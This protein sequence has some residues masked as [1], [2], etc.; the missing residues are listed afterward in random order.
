MARRYRWQSIESTWTSSATSPAGTEPV[1]ADLYP[2]M[3]SIADVAEK[4]MAEYSDLLSP[5]TVSDIVLRAHRELHGEVPDETLAERLYQLARR[6]L[7]G[8]RATDASRR[9]RGRPVR[10]WP[11]PAAGPQE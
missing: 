4:L 6:R 2:P 7:D 10:G 1:T 3:E 8:E 9:I 5:A 11:M